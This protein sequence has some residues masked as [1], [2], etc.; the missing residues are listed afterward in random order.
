MNR[1]YNDIL[2]GNITKQLIL[3]LFPA[4]VG[5]LLQ[6]VYGFVD[7]VI[8][9][10]FVSTEALAGVGATAM[11]IN[12]YQNFISGITAAIM[13]MMAQAMGKRNYEDIHNTV[14][15]GFFISIVMGIIFTL[16]GLFLSE[17]L[18]KIM[19]TPEDVIN[20]SLTYTFWYF[21]SVTFYIIYNAGIS[22]LRAMGDS[23]KPVYFIVVICVIKIGFDLLLAGV[24]GLGVL[25]TSIATFLSHFICAVLIF[26]LFMS[27]SDIYRYNI[28]EDFG[29]DMKTLKD[30]FKIGVP[31]G[32]QSMVFALTSV[33]IQVKINSF[34]TDVVAAFSAYN[35]VDDLF[36]CYVGG[37]NAAATTIAGQNYGNKNIE[38]VNKTLIYSLVLYAA[39]ALIYGFGFGC[40]GANLMS[41][42][43][44]DPDVISIGYEML[45][46]VCFTYIIYGPL[47][48][49]SCILKCTG[50]S[51]ISMIISIITIC[52]VRIIFLMIVPLN[53]PSTPIWSYP[54]S[55]AISSLVFII[56][57]MFDKK[58]K[59]KKD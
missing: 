54:V 56:Y 27:T 52:V 58:L 3:L 25:G 50:D 31:A 53:A 42:F 30:T 48:M 43:S 19:N 44:S 55:W 36:W 47:E 7:S 14:K 16:M 41:L 26:L 33:F 8:L 18:L 40:F 23:R 32:I 4:F 49:I 24:F 22:M 1:S 57:Y 12:M 17:P 38:R 10:R 9:G 37:V 28:K 15:T 13:V 51:F 21:L 5:L 39:G 46:V 29:F 35:N 2:N 45:K 6:Q 34:G 11:M 20:Y 59:V